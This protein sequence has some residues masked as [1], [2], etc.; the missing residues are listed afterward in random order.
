MKFEFTITNKVDTAIWNNSN[1]KLEKDLHE[2]MES[3]VE[4]DT[5]TTYIYDLIQALKPADRAKDKEMLFLMYDEPSSMPAD[6]RVEYV[7][8]P[9][10]FA[11]TIL[12]TAMTRF[13]NIANDSVI[14]NV[15]HNV[16]N[17][18]MGRNFVGAGYNEYVGLIETLRIFSQGDTLGFIEKF[19]TVNER[20]ACKF[21]ETLVFLENEIC[22]GKITDAWSG[23][24]YIKKGKEI[25]AM[26]QNTN[27][28]ESTHVWY[29]CYGSNLNKARFMEYIYS[30]SDETPPEEDR[31]F[32]FDHPIYF[33]KNSSRWQGGGKA[34]LDDSRIGTAYGRIYK[35]TREQYE[36]IKQKEG[37]DYTKRLSFGE[38]DG[39]PVYSFTDELV[40]TTV[41]IPSNEYFSTILAGMKECYNEILSNVEIVN[42]LIDSIFPKNTFEVARVIKENPHYISN[43]EISISVGME[44]S[45]VISATLWLVNNN[46]IQQDRRSIL[47]GHQINNS[48][49]FFFTVASPCGRELLDE[50][51]NSLIDEDDLSCSINGEVEG[52]RR[53][54]FA[55]RIERSH[56]NRI[57]AIKFHGYKC[58]VC[59]FDF[60]HF[61][62]DLGKNYI[63]VHHIN[64]LAEQDGEQIVN[65]ET[66]L[67]CL[68]ANCHRMIHRSR[69]CVLTVDE[70]KSIIANI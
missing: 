43:A 9:T 11:A 21:E 28:P 38:I 63:E 22:T 3:S 19:R 16:L 7:Y 10:Y 14:R 5:I 12:M 57:N 69:E 2:L 70:L 49:A 44:L 42:Y 17:A 67:V 68:C 29:A 45:D 25:L 1:I 37:S 20:F 59:D 56:R 50:I 60:A 62:G 34:F 64:P 47:A 54:V 15:T 24:D 6:A 46:V 18:A 32:I 41:R 55:S 61:Y 65:P 4:E 30:C 33:A 31:P 36:E 40:S 48:E 23:E 58:K 52:D 8:K 27:I 26:Y 53:Y 66:D 13:D 39:L 35:I 51:I